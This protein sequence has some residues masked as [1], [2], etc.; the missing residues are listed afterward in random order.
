M[1]I[2]YTALNT[3]NY[4]FQGQNCLAKDGCPGNRCPDFVIKRRDTKPSL[5]IPVEECGEPMDL[6]GLVVEVSMWAVAKLKTALTAEATYFRLADDIGFEQVMVGDTIIMDRARLPEK[7]LVTGFDETNKLIQVERGY[8]STTAC[9]WV[10]GSKLRIFR[11]INGVG[12]Y[13]VKLEDIENPDG[14]TD[15]DQLTES[16]LVYDWMAEN[17][18]LPGCYW[19][20]FAT[21]KMQSAVFFLPGGNWT[22]S[23]HQ[24]DDGYFYTGTDHTDSSVRLSYDQVNDIYL[25][26]TL[27]WGGESHVNEGRYFTGDTQDDG[28]VVL[29]LTGLSSDYNISYD[30]SGLLGALSTSEP[31]FTDS[32]LTPSSFG[33]SLSEGVE[34][35]RKFP[36]TD[37]LLIRVIDSPT[38]V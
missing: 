22:G 15:A 4:Y 14:T 2:Q 32:E 33:C 28:S 23:N 9:D 25:L 34:W 35:V 37:P 29:T 17:T 10:K 12:R 7:M 30:E 5:K 1:G 21:I 19:L 27:V 38:T 16:Y 26:P 31:T 8:Q 24:Y 13:E 3:S 6:R 11:I 18:C 36:S 20:E